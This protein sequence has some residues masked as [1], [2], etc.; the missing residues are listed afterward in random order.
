V[1][2]GAGSEGDTIDLIVDC[3]AVALSSVLVPD[4]DGD[5]STKPADCNDDNPGIHPGA[6]DIPENGVDENCDGA[7]AVILDRDRDGF[8]RPLDCNDNDARVH[9]GAVD[10]P[11]NRVDE[12]CRGG[13]APFPVLPSSVTVI[14]RLFAA[15]TAFDQV[16]VRRAQA[17]STVV[18][19][20][21]GPGC[22]SKDARARVKRSRNKLVISNPLRGAR[23]RAGARLEVRITK[24]RTVG[25]VARYS[26]RSGAAPART[27][28]CLRPA[29]K[30]PGRCPV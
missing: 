10:I 14:F 5:G 2:C 16:I 17:G 18:I 19:R 11:G 30:R 1:E 20:C 26:V 22:P 15:D 9:P 6:V 21:T 27:D 23:L 3:E 4:A 29:A 12:D 24:P 7:D 25:L 13:A 8:P 28:L